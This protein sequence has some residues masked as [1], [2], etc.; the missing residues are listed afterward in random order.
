MKPISLS[1][2]SL[3]LANLFPIYGIF[4][5]GWDL[6]TIF[7]VYLIENLIIAF[8]TVLKI[9]FLK[10]PNFKDIPVFFTIYERIYNIVGFVFVCLF[11]NG[12][13]YGFLNS[14]LLKDSISIQDSVKLAI[15]LFISHLISFFSNYF[16]KL[17]YTK[18]KAENL[19]EGYMPRILTMHLTI[20]FGSFIMH[21]IEEGDNLYLLYV[22]V[23][24]KIIS[25]LRAHNKEH[26]II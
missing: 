15:P 19:I 23:L 17:E 1:S 9:I 13:Y 18:L 8:F 25:D 12:I 20:I 4:H 24:I 3:V 6:K 10:L 26:S 21:T 22:L 7:L 11:F 14:L 5:L 16:V 2:V